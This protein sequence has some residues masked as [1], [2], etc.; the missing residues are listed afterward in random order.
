MK[1]RY[2][3][4]EIKGGRVIHMRGREGKGVRA[5]RMGGKSMWNKK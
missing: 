2:V 1:G 5:G 4:G 3:W